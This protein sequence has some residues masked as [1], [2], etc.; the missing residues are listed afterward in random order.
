[1]SFRNARETFAEAFL[2][3]FQGNGIGNDLVN[4]SCSEGQEFVDIIKNGPT[5]AQSFWK[6]P[7]AKANTSSHAAK[8]NNNVGNKK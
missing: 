2:E 1:M 6:E 4:A 7:C 3:S 8:V 5:D